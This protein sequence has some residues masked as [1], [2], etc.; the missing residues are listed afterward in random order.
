MG[1]CSLCKT[2]TA[3]LC[4]NSELKE[5]DSDIANAFKIHF[6]KFVVAYVDKM[7]LDVAPNLQV[8]K[9][10]IAKKHP[11]GNVFVIPNISEETVFNF[12]SSIDIKKTTGVDDSWARILKLSAQ[13]ITP[14]ITKICNQSRKPNIFPQQWEAGIS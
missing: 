13:H 10:F 11:P 1:Y 9:A 5:N 8:L 2:G 4:I 12:L 7:E 3:N 14:I 6:I